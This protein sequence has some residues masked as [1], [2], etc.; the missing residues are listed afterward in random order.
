MDSNVFTGEKFTCPEGDMVVLDIANG[1]PFNYTCKDRT[2]RKCF[3]TELGDGNQKQQKEKCLPI[4]ETSC[5]GAFHYGC[6]GDLPELTTTTT[7][8]ASTSTGAGD[9]ST[10]TMD[11]NNGNG[12]KTLSLTHSVILVCLLMAFIGL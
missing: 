10:T 2:L 9:G 8:P 3:L 6:N 11:G 4:T 5:P 1:N 7:T 12:V